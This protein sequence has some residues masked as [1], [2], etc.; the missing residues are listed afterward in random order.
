MNANY[1]LLYA[2]SCKLIQSHG[3]FGEDESYY[4]LDPELFYKN[5]IN[6]IIK[7][8]QEIEF[9]GNTFDNSNCLD[10]FK[11]RQM[12]LSIVQQKLGKMLL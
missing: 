9:D 7:T 12:A 4:K 6:D 10:Y 3:A 8:V 1:D 11:G 2:M 5:I